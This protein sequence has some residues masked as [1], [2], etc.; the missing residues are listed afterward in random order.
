MI[1]NILAVGAGSC[2]GGLCRYLLARAL[3]M[4]GTGFPWGTFAANLGG[5]LVIG[6]VCGAILAQWRCAEW[7]RLLLTVGFCGGFTTF[8][9][10]A[11]ETY[12]MLCAREYALAAT[13]GCSSLAGGLLLVVAGYA[14][15]QK[16]S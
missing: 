5:C 1:E 14:L 13:Y 2:L 7:L 11:N 16:I 15:G 3:P 4:Q 6:I 10:F 9:T 12:A 8:S